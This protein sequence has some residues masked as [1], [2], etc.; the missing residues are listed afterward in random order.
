[1]PSQ[2]LVLAGSSAIRKIKDA[3]KKRIAGYFRM[4]SKFHLRPWSRHR[5]FDSKNAIANKKSRNSQSIT[6]LGNQLPSCGVFAAHFKHL[7]A[8]VDQIL[9][10]EGLVHEVVC[11][12]GQQ[13]SD[14]VLF[15]HAR[16]TNDFASLH[17][18][19]TANA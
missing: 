3:K 8:T 14:F 17:G 16:N 18:R 11:T 6:P 10:I 7:A 2:F 19:I 4:R 13:V 15:N 12:S 1:M 5:S 9:N